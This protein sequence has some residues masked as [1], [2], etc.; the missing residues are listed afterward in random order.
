MLINSFWNR[1]RRLFFI[2][3]LFAAPFAPLALMKVGLPRIHI[4]DRIQAW[5]VHPTAEALGNATGG[6]GVL[7][8][9]YVAVVGA[10]DENEKLKK[11]LSEL[12]G[13]ILNLAETTHEN[14]R[15][16]ALLAIPD[17][18]ERKGLGAKI[19]G[20]DSSHESLSFIVNV[21][22]ADGVRPRMPVVHVSGI[23]GTV[24]RVYRNSSVFLSFLDPNHDVDGLVARTRA[25]AVVEGKGQ[26]LLARLKYLD[27]SDDLRVGDLLITSGIDGVFPKGLSIGSV[28]KVDKPE[29]GVTQEAELRAAVDPGHLEEVVILR[30]TPAAESEEVTVS[31]GSP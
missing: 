8:A 11:E 17:L 12:Q 26:N 18:A 1:H 25:R 6:A 15:L 22:S 2:V 19:I 13:Q 9:R 21:G 31:Q 4:Y 30:N 7:W 23:V 29:A 5:F 10:H 3:A 27:R 20:Q 16:R 28:V 24:S 14:D